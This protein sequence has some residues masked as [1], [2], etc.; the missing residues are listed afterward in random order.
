[1][2]LAVSN[3]SFPFHPASTLTSN[4][5]NK[6]VGKQLGKARAT[7]SPGNH[8]AET[9]SRD[10]QTSA[11]VSPDS[12]SRLLLVLGKK[13]LG[14]QSTPTRN[15]GGNKIDPDAMTVRPGF[16]SQG[17]K[18]WVDT[19]HFRMTLEDLDHIYRHVVSI[20]AN[21]KVMRINKDTKVREPM[22]VE[23]TPKRTRRILEQICE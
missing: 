19:N 20:E 13:Q 2:P 22:D 17:T 5:D 4:M 1:M 15:A 6:A 9:L 21:Y 14:G 23:M 12:T 8:T 10:G 18:I 7:E 11:P 3:D 16:G